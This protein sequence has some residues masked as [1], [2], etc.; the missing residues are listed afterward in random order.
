MSRRRRHRRARGRGRAWLAH[1]DPDP[2]DPRRARRGLDRGRRGDAA[3][4]ADLADRFGGAARVRHGRAARRARR[5]PEPDEPRPSCIRAAAGLAALPAATPRRGDAGVVVGLRRPPQLRRLRARHRRRR[6]RRRASGAVCCPQPLPTPVLAFADPPPR[7]D[8]GVMVTA[9]HNP[10]QRQRLQGLPRRRRPDRPAGRRRDRRRTSTPSARLA[11]C[12]SALDDGSVDRSATSS[13]GRLPRRRGRHA[14]RRRAA[15]RRCR[16]VVHADARRRAAHVP[17]AASSRAGFAGADVVAEQVGAGPG[18]P[19]RG[20]PEPGG[21]GRDRPRRSRPR[22][23]S[24]PT[25]SSP[26]TPTPTGCAVGHPRPAARR[27]LADAARRRGRRAAR[28]T[29]AR[30]DRGGSRPDAVVATLDRRPRAAGRDRRGAPACDYEETLTGF[31]WIARAPA[32]PACV[33]GYEE[34]LGYCVAPDIVRDKDG[35]SAAARWSP[36]S[37]PSSKAEGR[38]LQRPPRRARPASTALHATGQ[39]SV[40]VELDRARPHRR[41][42]AACGP[43]RPPRLAGRRGRPG[44]RPRR[45]PPAARCRRATCLR[46]TCD[47]ARVIVRP[48][49]TEPKLKC[50][51]EV[52]VAVT[53]DVAAARAEAE[54]ALDA[55]D[56][57]MP[58]VSPSTGRQARLRHERR[59]RARSG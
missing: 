41:A 16:I 30:C 11:T 36:S 24:A 6:G 48:S 45:A 8:A 19:D 29:H 44:R 52:V 26:T 43:S 10:P 54:A 34:A 28:P 7:R 57:A 5:R 9:S 55:L 2:D 4:A 49:G 25:S 53:A 22:A 46:S 21:A 58:S 23:R 12:R 15:A 13:L 40:R 20:L 17:S 3:A 59:Q 42:M 32:R 37:R 39:C 31:K 51:L 27:R 18:L 33:F 14:R 47:G 1:D 56:T 38:T 35:I 50:Y